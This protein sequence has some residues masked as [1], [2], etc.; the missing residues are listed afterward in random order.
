MR[1]EPGSKLARQLEIPTS[2]ETLSRLVLTVGLRS[3]TTD[4]DNISLSAL[5]PPLETI[6]FAKVPMF[7]FLLMSNHTVNTLCLRYYYA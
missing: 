3:F 2:T 7:G 1:E 4:P 5:A 6:W